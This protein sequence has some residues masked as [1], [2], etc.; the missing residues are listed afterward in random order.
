MV[1]ARVV[2]R[3][4]RRFAPGERWGYNRHDEERE[5]TKARG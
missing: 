2:P 5:E 4:V 1:L 3:P